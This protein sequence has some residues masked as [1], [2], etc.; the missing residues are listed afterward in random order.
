[1]DNTF[2]AEAEHRRSAEAL[3]GGF[4]AHLQAMRPHQWVKNVL[5]LLPLALAHQASNP[6]KLAAGLIATAAFCL[7]A[8]A[9]YLMN[10]LMDLES[11]R[12][13]PTKRQRPLA[14][15]RVGVPWAV[16]TCVV[17]VIGSFAAA[18]RLPV[19][20]QVILAAYFVLTTL[21]SL[22][23][24]RKVLV[25][26]IVLSSLYTLRIIAGAAAVR[27]PLTMWLLAFSMF[28]FL[29]LAFV[30]RYSE[31]VGVAEAGGEEAAGRGYHVDDLRIIETVG[32]ASGYLSVLV[33]CT[34]LDSDLVRTLYPHPEVLWLAAPLLL[35]WITRIW[36]L[37]RRQ[38]IH[39]DP[40]MFALRDKV[41]WLTGFL[42]VLVV[43]LARVPRPAWWTS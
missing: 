7:C 3:P 32:P 5:L 40:I 16:G 1:M 6:A 41:S 33:F 21:Y 24:K 28:L 25:D 22:W 37:A 35:Y 20:F 30:K 19:R 14:A 31:L 18:I 17:L 34:Y 10:D 4:G 29:S 39:E 15:G 2:H 43:L 13:H 26:V 38:T 27:V 12:R 23:L 36:F 42:V 11:D 9:V 8:S